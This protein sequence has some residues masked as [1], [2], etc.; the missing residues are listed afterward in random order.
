LAPSFEPDVVERREVHATADGECLGVDWYTVAEPG[1]VVALLPALGVRGRYYRHAARRLA[2]KGHA[3]AVVAMRG[4]GAPVTP[5][6]R[7]NHGYRE[8]L[9]NDLATVLPSI[10]RS[11]ARPFFV[12]GHSLGGQLALLHASRRPEGIRGVAVIAGG[13]THHA[14]LP[15]GRRAARRASVWAVR[16]V[17]EAL[18]FFPG[19]KL[20]F[21]GRQPKNMMLDWAEEGLTGRYRILGD[22]RDPE[23]DLAALAAPVLFVCLAGDRLVPE[24]AARFLG[25]KL[26]ASRTRFVCLGPG[27]FDGPVDHFRWAKHPAPVVDALDRWIASTAAEPPSAAPATSSASGTCP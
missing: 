14:A 3:V 12:A 9:E 16:L 7:G 22:A 4:E 23:A 27:D 13:S 25:R 10:R 17:T 2:A 8:V 20:G 18:G 6:R 5:T 11:T 15:A 24:A 26:T 21:A 19:D 1:S